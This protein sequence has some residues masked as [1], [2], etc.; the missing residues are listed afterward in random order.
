MSNPSI[1][2]AGARRTAIGAMLGQF[3]GVPATQL[4]ST[5]IKAALADS[6][7]APADVSEVIMGCVLPANLGQA[8]A[9]QAAL[10][11]GVPA[12]AGASAVM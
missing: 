8:P 5:A 3:T 7:I 11:A 12:S 4:G 1:V 6:G 9:R 10:N 2:I